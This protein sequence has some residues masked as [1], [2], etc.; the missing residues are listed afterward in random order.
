MREC[1]NARM[2]ECANARMRLLAPFTVRSMADAIRMPKRGHVYLLLNKP[3]FVPVLWRVPFDPL[4]RWLHAQGDVRTD[5]TLSNPPA[6]LDL[7]K[8]SSPFRTA[9]RS[10]I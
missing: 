10:C 5:D 2:R 1:A 4:T 3:G 7:K 6:G 8:E 9:G